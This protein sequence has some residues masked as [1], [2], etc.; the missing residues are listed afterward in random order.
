MFRTV[1]W[2]TLS[3]FDLYLKVLNCTIELKLDRNFTQFTPLRYSSLNQFRL[4]F[5][6]N[7]NRSIAFIHFDVSMV[8]AGYKCVS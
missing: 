7:I 6:P 3:I 1:H 2:M 4:I 8:I 5:V